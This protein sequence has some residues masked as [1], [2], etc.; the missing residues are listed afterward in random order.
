MRIVFTGGGTGGHIFPVIAIIRELRKYPDSKKL[1]IFYIGPK[2]SF[3]EEFLKKEDVK[4]K[5][6]IS[7]K[8]RRYVTSS[9]ILLNFLDLFFK[10]PAGFFQSLFFL[11]SIR[12]KLIF[13]KGGYGSLPVVLAAYFLKIPIFL[14]ES[15]S[16]PGKVNRITARFAERILTSFPIQKIKYFQ[17]KSGLLRKKCIFVGNPVRKEILAGDKE[18]GKKIFNLTDEK[19]VLLVLGGS[20]GAQRIND[21]ILQTLPEILKLFEVI[22]QCGEKNLKDMLLQTKVIFEKE[23]ALEKYYHLYGFL[24]EDKLKHAYKVAHLV[25]SRAG[26]GSIFEILANGLPSILVPLPE[27][28]QNHQ[29]ENAYII[30]D[31]GAALVIEQSNFRPHFLMKKLHMFFSHPETL[32]KMR[33][34]AEKISIPNSAEIIAKILLKR[35]NLIDKEGNKG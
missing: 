6:I 20:Q 7:G 26:A 8:L 25:I 30:E 33:E 12:P 2:D 15:D 1:E 16:I 22:H 9:S 10:I 18:T 24:D 13:S 35:L 27:S 11:F 29:R 3:F 17:N 34:K 32:K 23:K 5:T 19:P 4:T 14:H 31:C 21:V 28:A